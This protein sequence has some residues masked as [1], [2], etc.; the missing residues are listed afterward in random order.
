MDMMPAPLN[1]VVEAVEEAI[2]YA[3]EQ[4]YT[5]VRDALIAT[6]N[7]LMASI[8]W[9]LNYIRGYIPYIVTGVLT[10]TM[11]YKFTTSE[12]MS[13]EKK[14]VG[15]AS[16]PFLAYISGVLIDSFLPREVRLPRWTYPAKMI[17]E[18]DIPI[19]AYASYMLRHIV[20][21]YVRADAETDA[22]IY[23]V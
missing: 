15:I 8:E 9:V 12:R 23:T 10:W 3:V 16:A 2:S 19:D 14:I 6:Y 4:V 5:R 1:E 18:G 20:V 13:I 7:W 21:Y 22:F 11:I 17:A